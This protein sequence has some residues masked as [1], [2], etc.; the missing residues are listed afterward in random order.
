MRSRQPT[1]AAKPTENSYKTLNQSKSLRHRDG[2]D[3]L[4]EEDIPRRNG[5]DTGMKLPSIRSTRSS[6]HLDDRMKSSKMTN[7][8]DNPKKI[9]TSGHHTGDHERRT[10]EELP[11]IGRRHESIENTHEN[12]LDS[13]K[14]LHFKNNCLL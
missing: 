3:S 6:K 14:K 10:T 2:D 7:S 8:Y 12:L 1:G 4:Q 5:P 13:G 9:K 11:C